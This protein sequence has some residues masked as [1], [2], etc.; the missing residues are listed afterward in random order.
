MRFRGATTKKPL[1]TVVNRNR[2]EGGVGGLIQ[3]TT[4]GRPPYVQVG[5]VFGD[6]FP[7][8]WPSPSY[9]G[10]GTIRKYGFGAFHPFG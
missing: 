3:T 2:P 9:F 6:E 8:A 7:A 4:I 1:Q 5:A 10:C